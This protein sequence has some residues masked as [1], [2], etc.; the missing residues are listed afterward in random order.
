LR[1]A[2]ESCR[3]QTYENIEVIV[4]VGGGNRFDEVAADYPNVRFVHLEANVPAASLNA[5][6]S[7][8]TGEYVAILNDDDVYFPEHV[9]L[10]AGAL[11]RTGAAVAHGDVLTAFLQGDDSGWKLYGF[12]SNMS[13][14]A[15]RS[16]LLVANYIGAMSGMVRRSC[17][18]ATLYDMQIPLY[19]DY[20]FWLRLAQRYDFVHVER[21][22]SCYTI[23]N[24]GRE[25]QTQLT[26]QRAVDAFRAI[27]NAFP[28]NDRPLLE[29]QRQQQLQTVGQ[30][31]TFAAW[32]SPAGQIK[33]EPWP[34]F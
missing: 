5:A 18:G 17:I 14:S 23:R 2:L 1:Y 19:R 21:I 7:Q 30:S 3:R 11:E 6:F 20:A 32:S 12:E 16:S 34:P 24:Q 13:R 26:S 33:P 9:S 25:Q 27:Y 10:L 8:A 28:L 31:G 22:T 4:A 29:Q 15:D